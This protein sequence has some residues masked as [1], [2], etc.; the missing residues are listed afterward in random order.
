MTTTLPSLLTLSAGTMKMSMPRIMLLLMPTYQQPL[1][2]SRTSLSMLAMSMNC[3]AVLM[4]T[5]T[6]PSSNFRLWQLLSSPY[7]QRS[8]FLKMCKTSL[9]RSLLPIVL[10][11]PC[12]RSSN[13]SYRPPHLVSPQFPCQLRSLLPP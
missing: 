7:G 9:M 6:P 8:I 4:M 5:S 13:P 11:L 12:A 3:S 1:P 10:S 2:S